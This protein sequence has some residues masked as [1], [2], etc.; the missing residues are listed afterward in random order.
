MYSK[1]VLK[2]LEFV[3]FGKEMT[4][5]RRRRTVEVAVSVAKSDD[6]L[7]GAGVYRRTP[8]W[9]RCF[10]GSDFSWMPA[11]GFLDGSYHCLLHLLSE[12]I[13]MIFYSHHSCP[14]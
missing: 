7:G 12:C 10:S 4:L 5:S 2:V 13:A 1:K 14:L 11:E 3:P 9:T 8:E 6:S